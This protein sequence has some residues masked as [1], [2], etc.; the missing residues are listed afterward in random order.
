[1]KR[2]E[3]ISLLG[4]AAAAWCSRRARSRAV[5]PL[6]YHPLA[7]LSLSK[8]TVFCRHSGGKQVCSQELGRL[9]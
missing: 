3:F 5:L 6:R 1:M 8:Q 9:K 2:R 4:G 7:D